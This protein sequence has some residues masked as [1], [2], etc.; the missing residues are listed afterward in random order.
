MTNTTIDKTRGTDTMQVET[1]S[2]ILATFIENLTYNG[3]PEQVVE[4]AK[5]ET[6]DLLGAI[7][8]GSQTDCGRMITQFALDQSG[9]PQATILGQ[10]QAVPSTSAALANGT[11]AFILDVDSGEYGSMA[12]IGASVLPALLAAAEQEDISGP[13]FITALVAGYDVAIRIG[14]AVQPSHRA[15]GFWSIGT[16][17][18]FGA[19]AAVAKA[20]RLTREQIAH[21]IGLA[22]LQASGLGVVEGVGSMGRQI[23]VGKA[24]QN[25]VLAALIAE[26][27]FTAPPEVLEG[28]NGFLE[29]MTAHYDKEILEKN[30]GESFLILEGYNKP[31]PSCRFT[32]VALDALFELIEAHDIMPEHVTSISC[33]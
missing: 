16:F 21:T 26:R 23:L 28:E 20:M 22:G 24:A 4:K 8:G 18:T 17:P 27:G 2:M 12:H 19:S 30:M 14:R 7:F 13:D 15:R 25:G 9:T 33:R 3:L 29:T 1:Q 6:L 31:Y 5:I 32:H 10:G 11:M